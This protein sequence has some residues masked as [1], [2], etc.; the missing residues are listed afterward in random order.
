MKRTFVLVAFLIL[1]FIVYIFS[2]LQY[3]YLSSLST[4]VTNKYILYILAGVLWLLAIFVIARVL[5]K[6]TYAYNKTHWILFV[7]LNP[8]LGVI[9]FFLFAREFHTRRFYKTRPLIANRAFLGLE[10]NYLHDYEKTE[11][12]RI[13]KFIHET[14]GRA[15]YHNDTYVEILNNGDIFFPKLEKELSAAVDYIF[16]EFYIVKTDEIGRKILNILKTKAQD[17]LDVYLIYD[18]FGSNK[19]IDQTYMKELSKAGVKIGVFDPQQ[20]SVFNS[21]LNFRNH[22]KAIVIDGKVGFVGGMNLGDEYNHKSKKFGFWRDTHVMLKGNGVTG[23]QNVFVKDWYYITGDVIDKPMD[24]TVEDFPG[25]VTI[26][27]S[28]PDFEDGLIRDTYIKM[29]HSAEK[30]IKIV[31]P[32]LILEPEI[33]VAIKVALMSGVK[34]D[35]LVPGFHDY[36]TVGLAT[37]SYYEQLLKLGVRIYEYDKHF[38]HSKILVI[39]DKIA[40]VGSVNF[41][42]RSFHLSFEVTA[43][44][45]NA[46]VKDLVESFQKD[47]TKSNEIILDEWKKRGLFHKI[48]QGLFNL[49]SPMY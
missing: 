39:D 5:L 9:L 22:R 33:M 42:P 15:V 34:I 6:P 29:I 8:I 12:G 47:L 36:L 19:H 23:V 37:K 13:F 27:E 25:F 18:H 10:E 43:V 30:S 20:I 44:F 2:L 26:L 49:F 28:G 31:T 38:V 1:A 32:Y 21:N 41:D 48:I 16:M 3:I 40:S 24:K 45:E 7:M 35:L 11:F 17:G 46:A 4:V 14:T